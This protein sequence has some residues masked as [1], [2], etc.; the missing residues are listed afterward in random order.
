MMISVTARLL[1]LIMMFFSSFTYAACELVVTVPKLESTKDN[2][3]NSLLQLSINKV[4]KNVCYEQNNEIITEARKAKLIAQDVI[5]VQWASANSIAEEFLQHI[6]QP[7]F[8]G[9]MGFRIFVIRNDEQ[10]RFDH[11]TNV[12]QLKEL[13]AGQGAFW[14][15]TKVLKTAGLPVVTATQGRRLWSM[16]DLKRFDYLPLGPHEPWKDLEIR[17]ELGFI[18]EKN[19]LLIYPSAMYFYVSNSNERLADII[20][21]GMKVA[22]ADGSYDKL[23]F[24]SDMLKGAIHNANLEK[25]RILVIDNP[26]YSDK[27]ID[28]NLY[29]TQSIQTIQNLVK[30]KLEHMV[31]A[32]E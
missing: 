6:E 3:I 7:I 18:V 27:N 13:V 25:R 26:F 29:K 8:K 21:R 17:P 20:S 10:H 1:I 12:Q 2:L 23:L 24:E 9:L 22:L 19:L 16:L 4:Q 5:S 28:L 31:L 32:G 14:G 30:L 11:I 15:D